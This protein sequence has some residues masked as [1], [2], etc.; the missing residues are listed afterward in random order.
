MKRPSSPRTYATV[1]VLVMGCSMLGA[2]CQGDIVNDPTFRDWCGGSLCSWK[3]DSGMIAQVPTWSD[4]DLGVSFGPGTEISQVTTES[5]ASCIVFTTVGDIDGTA[6]MTIAVDFNNDGSIDNTLTIG[7]GYWQAD[8]VFITAPPSYD[9]I[10]FYIKKGGTGTAILA[11]MRIQSSTGCTA[12]ATELTNLKL[13][14]GCSSGEGCGGSLTCELTSELGT[15]CSECASDAQCGDAGAK[16]TQR[17]PSFPFQCSPGEG[18]GV[19]NAPCLAN[20]DC[21]SGLCMGASA[22]VLGDGGVELDGGPCSLEGGSP[23]ASTNCA[24]YSLVGGACQ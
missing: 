14:E 21:L 1:A 22:F 6:Q 9:G 5:A 15:Q 19:S 10:T 12:A 18:R 20:D 24:G 8:T 13:G 2:D 4:S 3:T 11:E 16:C 7:S 23:D 17:G